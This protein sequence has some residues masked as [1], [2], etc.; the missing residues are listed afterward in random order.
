MT[1][2][3]KLWNGVAGRAWVDTQELLDRVVQPFEELLVEEVAG[4][5]RVLDVGCGTGAT[6]AAIARAGSEVVGVDISEPMIQAAKARGSSAQFVC[7]NAQT[8]EFER[9]SFD[10]VVSRFG[11]MFFDDPVAAFR[12]LRRAAGEMRVITWRSPAENPFMTT[13]ERAASSLMELPPR[14][15]GAPGQFG[16]ADRGR[17]ESILRESGWTDIEIRAL[18]VACAF[19]EKDLVSYFTRLGPVGLVFGELDE[20]AQVQVIDTVRAALAPYV[21]DGEVRFNAACWLVSARSG[22]AC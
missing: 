13:A 12:N 11:V 17:I 22:A 19:A 7:A 14:V 3:K 21:H 15:V 8:H 20:R 18:D 16:L 5:R 6:T 9:A 10:A 2:Q 4:K 1:E